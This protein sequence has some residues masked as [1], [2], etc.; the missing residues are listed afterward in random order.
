MVGSK[1]YGPNFGELSILGPAGPPSNGNINRGVDLENDHIET[2]T[3]TL[4]VGAPL[5]ICRGIGYTS[6]SLSLNV[7]VVGGGGP[8]LHLRTNVHIYPPF[9]AAKW[10]CLESLRGPLAVDQGLTPT[11]G[12]GVRVQEFGF[13]V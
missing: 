6:N 12:L 4:Q 2:L 11:S 1:N 7:S 9:A 13:R 10:Q 3:L 5:V 8:Y